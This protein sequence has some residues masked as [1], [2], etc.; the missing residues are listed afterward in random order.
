MKAGR[1]LSLHARRRG[2]R[3][4]P[5]GI[6][7][8]GGEVMQRVPERCV[9]PEEVG[10]LPGVSPQDQATPP[11]VAAD[12]LHIRTRHPHTPPH[13]MTSN[14]SWPEYHSDQ[15]ATP[16]RRQSRHRGAHQGALHSVGP[17]IHRDHDAGT[18]RGTAPPPQGPCTPPACRRDPA[19]PVRPVTRTRRTTRVP[20]PYRSS[21]PDCHS[22][23]AMSVSLSPPEETASEW[24]QRMDGVGGAHGLGRQPGRAGPNQRPSA[25]RTA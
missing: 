1:R 22:P 7:A 8:Y 20:G 2:P 4:T 18:E 10:L 3:M 13:A 25:D 11:R 5:Y 12:I 19:S 6:S 17:R 21:C 9:E 16:Q 15:R 23:L 24:R 14:R